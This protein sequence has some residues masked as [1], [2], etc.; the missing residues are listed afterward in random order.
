EV[1][2][3][4]R[5]R[6]QAAV[7]ADD[8]ERVV[9]VRKRGEPAPVADDD[10]NVV[11]LGEKR[12]SHRTQV[13]LA[14][15]CVL[16]ELASLRQVALRRPDVPAGLDAPRRDR[17]PYLLS[18]LGKLALNI[19]ARDDHIIAVHRVDGAV[20]RLESERAVLQVDGF[21][22]DRVAVQLGGTV[23]GDERY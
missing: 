5:I 6:I 22:A 4:E 15:R 3:V 11:A 23:D 19:S 21:I 14:I 8:V 1:G 16:E 9:R 13:A 17:N 20:D 12:S 2:D 7:P 18:G 10:R